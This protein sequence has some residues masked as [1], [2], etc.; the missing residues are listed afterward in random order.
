M[1]IVFFFITQIDSTDRIVEYESKNKHS[2]EYVNSKYS[3]FENTTTKTIEKFSKRELKEKRIEKSIENHK[4]QE[5][6]KKTTK[7]L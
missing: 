6:R 1:A 2:N 7:F 3:Y 4:K 5:L